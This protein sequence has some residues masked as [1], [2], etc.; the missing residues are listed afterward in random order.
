[1]E[2]GTRRSCIVKLL[3]PDR[4]H[5]TQSRDRLI[6]EGTLLTQLCHPH[7]DLKPSNIVAQAGKATLLDLSLAQ[8]PGP[9]PAGMGT[10]EYMAPEQVAGDRVDTPTDVWGLAGVLYRAATGRRPFPASEHGR[11]TTG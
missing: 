1:M 6:R 4:L 9:C 2:P 8:A 3:R 5:K 7:L 10:T 11:W